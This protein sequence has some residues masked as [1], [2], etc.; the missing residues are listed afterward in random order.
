MMQRNWQSGVA[1]G[2]LGPTIATEPASV[3]THPDRAPQLREVNA[4]LEGT[5]LPPVPPELLERIVHP[6]ALLSPGISSPIPDQQ[7]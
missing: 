5:G 3:D 7:Q 1:A 6:D 4:T 2:P